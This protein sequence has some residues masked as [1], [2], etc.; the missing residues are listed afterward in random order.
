MSTSNKSLNNS[1]SEALAATTRA[2]NA[3]STA[4]LSALAGSNNPRFWDPKI[5][6][7]QWYDTN[8]EPFSLVFPA[9]IEP[10]GKHSRIDPYFTLPT[11]KQ[12]EVKDVR[13][14]KAQF[15][16][17][18][19][20]DSY[21]S[22]AVVCS[23]KAANTLMLLISKCESIR[24]QDNREVIQFLR[25]AGSSSAD[26]L[27]FV[28]HTDPL[29][30]EA[31]EAKR[32]IVPE[33]SLEDFE[34]T[35]L[36]FTGDILKEKFGGKKNC[37]ES[38]PDGEERGVED[39][40]L[41]HMPDPQGHYHTVM[42]IFKLD[43]IPVVVPN[44]RDADGVLIHPS[45]YSQKLKSG[46]PVAVEVVM[47]LWTFA[48]DGK[49]PTGSRIYQTVLKSLKVLPLEKEGEAAHTKTPGYTAD[50]KGKRKADG[51]GGH[52]SPSKKAQKGAGETTV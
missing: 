28:V 23:K 44:V 52:A 17:R 21:P 38:V 51:L 20:D 18:T 46:Q 50:G 45:E 1:L 49:R 25:N 15:Q 5:R 37:G 16:L 30:P 11:L 27:H 4:R 39:W 48:P 7:E 2:G 13:T 31:G 29:F 10:T 12:P 40:K 14:V 3:A 8:G 34:N 43:E 35:D 32:E 22:D 42:K 33:F 26:P 47:R 9:L 19:L 41:M 6:S 24:G 36:T